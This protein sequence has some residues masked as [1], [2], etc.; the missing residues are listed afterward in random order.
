MNKPGPSDLEA[1]GFLRLSDPDEPLF[2]VFPYWFLEEGIRLRQL[3]LVDPA[4]W[5]DP[6]ERLP[7]Q[8]GLNDATTIPWRQIFLAA[9]LRTL[10]AQSWSLSGSSDTLLRAYSRV[11]KDP[12]IKRNLTPRDEGVRV[13]STARKLLAVLRRGHASANESNSFVGRVSYAP[14]ADILQTCANWVGARGAAFF[15]TGRPRAELSLLKRVEFAHEAEV[16]LIFIEERDGSHEQLLRVPAD[17]N[18]FIDEIQFDPRLEGFEAKEHESALRALGYA[19]PVTHPT[20]YN[21]NIW[22][23]VAPSGEPTE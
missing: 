10:F 2:R 20:T 16:R 17:S 18:D 3:V 22:L 8:I 23:E 19:G 21:L 6:F 14:Q 15:S 1:Q 9:Y 11:H 7:Q 13:Q 5:E 4:L 12:H